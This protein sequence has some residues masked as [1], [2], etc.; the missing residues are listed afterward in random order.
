MADPIADLLI[1][2]RADIDDA[3][4]GLGE[5]EKSVG[6]FGKKLS[7][8]A[9][10]AGQGL[11]T[12]GAPLVAFGGIAAK[13]A[14]DFEAQMNVLA[15]AA[16]GSG[17][18]LEDLRNVA[19]A[20]GDDV[21][22]MGVS[23]SDVAGAMTN[24][25]KAGLD[26]N[27]TL[28]NMQGYL[29][30][31]TELGGALRAAIDLAAAS[32]L[33]LS[34]ASELVTTTMSTFGLSAD[35][36][37][38]KIGNYVQ[39]ADASVA[40]VSDLAD[41]MSNVGPTMAAF[42]FGLED[43]NTALA[44]LST[45]GIK[46]AEAG[47]ALKSMF[48]NM[49]SSSKETQAA[50]AALN[51]S[52]YD[53]QGRMKE[54]PQ[55]IKEL[56]AALDLQAE[57][58]IMVGGATKA[59]AAELATY[60]K[61]ITSLAQSIEMYSTGAKG[62]SMTEKAR[63]KKL[64]DLNAELAFYQKKHAD[65]IAVLP[66]A[67]QATVKMTE[68]QRNQYV[69][70]IAGTY[71]MKAMNTLLA[72][73]A[74]G[75]DEMTQSIGS[76]ATMQ[77]SAAAQTQG[78]NAAM[79]NL[80]SST[81]TFL[82]KVGTPLI[83]DVLTP[84]VKTLT[85]VVGKLAE[86]NPAFFKWAVIIG[87]VMTAL[88]GL[89]IAVG[90]IAGAI[91]SIKTLIGVLGGLSKLA[92]LGSLITG[93]IIPALGA[94]GAAI[95]PILPIILAVAA[96]AGLLYLA[97]KNNFLGLRDLV[98]QVGAAISAVFNFIKEVVTAF[99]QFL[100][101]QITWEE[102]TTRVSTAFSVMR[103]QLAGIWEA[104]KGIIFNAWET[105]KTVVGNALVTV[106]TIVNNALAAIWTAIVNAWEA[107]KTAIFSALVAIVE[108]VTG[109]HEQAVA[110]VTAAWENIKAII[111]AALVVLQAIVS[112]AWQTIS[113]FTQTVWTAITQYL[114]TVWET[115]KSIITADVQLVQVILQAAWEAI[116]AVAIAVWEAIKLAIETILTALRTLITA[117]LQAIG[118][119][120]A[121]AWETIRAG[122]VTALENLKQGAETIITNLKTSILNILGSLV[123]GVYEK[124]RALAQRFADG[125]ISALNAAL[126]AAR[127]IAQAIRDLLPGSDAKK[128][129][130]SD[131]F[132]SG[133]ALPMTLA[134]GI[135]R[136]SGRML[137]AAE[138]LAGG[139]AAVLPGL[140]GGENAPAGSTAAV[141]VLVTNWPAG[142]LAGVGGAASDLAT[143]AAQLKETT[144]AAGVHAGRQPEWDPNAVWRKSKGA[145]VDTVE[146]LGDALSSEFIA[147]KDTAAGVHAGRQPE[148]D[149]AAIWRQS[150]D[151]LAN[152]ITAVKDTVT[153]PSAHMGRQPEWD[154]NTVL[155]TSAE[156]TFPAST[157]GQVI[158]V[159][160]N[161]PRG[162]PT[163][164]SVL[165]TLKNLAAIGVLQPVALS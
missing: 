25:V 128:G 106:G 140:A 105:I 43:V 75:W 12:L 59:Q 10:E 89:L 57:R 4:K 142:G 164:T 141:P 2:V 159:V 3:L 16:R 14:G 122:T 160:V 26:V 127:R 49:M 139:A 96:V 76:A 124:G 24:F 94:L 115:I 165:R 83:K 18:S 50:L 61:K 17:T 22:L 87:V 15:V 97:W 110:I 156:N 90:K 158:N 104:I 7:S 52:L 131:L 114:T 63:T 111:N 126:E 92:G 44:I 157:P 1:K 37:V 20:A 8:A 23:A 74:A 88:G 147:L 162:E 69:Q 5:A 85:A 136:G 119:D 71:G 54:L 109:N 60:E 120:W 144:T 151:A 117:T 102:F 100:T 46:G 51:V 93:T 30:G 58:T 101:G 36:V 103:D 134:R 62:A 11:A 65:L 67:T 137:T 79:E 31:T 66:Q 129:P 70:T 40:S 149:P 35:E 28:G 32:E 130:L 55:I 153:S 135:Q 84:L 116:K 113:T 108:S 112:T 121:G 98:A 148:W 78:F 19:I 161:N 38:G 107:I 21:R 82:I 9:T 34:Q 27:D 33:D 56:S 118:G 132:A 53:S 133:R 73:G 125:V 163:E 95:L 6:G 86:V 47:T 99:W 146:K 150:K 152:V 29:S 13:V 45:R 80:K 143:A 155:K 42:G 145:L 39:A 138:D 77:Q 91:T 41:A 72:E 81:E 123:A 154:P 64:Q 68:A 48:T